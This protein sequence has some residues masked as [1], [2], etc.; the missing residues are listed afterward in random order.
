MEKVTQF[1]LRN[2]R[3][4]TFIDDVEVV[5]VDTPSDLCVLSMPE[6]EHINAVPIAES[7]PRVGSPIW[8]IAAPY[9]IFNT[10]MVPILSGIW[11]GRT[12]SGQSFLCDL[13]ASPGSSGSAVFNTE[14]EIVSIVLATNMQFHHASFGATLEQIRD[15][16]GE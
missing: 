11:C 9:G 14:G 2:V 16:I 12:P 3:G 7:D 8:N 4:E 10:G 15:I 1:E 6:A 13:P 5:A